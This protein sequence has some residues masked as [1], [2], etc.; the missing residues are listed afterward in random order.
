M[1]R[2]KKYAHGLYFIR[3]LVWLGTGRLYLSPRTSLAL[4]QSFD[5][6]G[7]WEENM[8]VV[9]YPFPNF[10]GCTISKEIGDAPDYDN[11]PTLMD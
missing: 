3:V 2:A 1:V 11:I 9:T 4:G 6:P 10:N 8:N 7:A 5:Y